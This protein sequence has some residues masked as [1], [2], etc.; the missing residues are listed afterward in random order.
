M[1]LP[2]R[3]FATATKGRSTP[4]AISLHRKPARRAVAL[5]Y[6]LFCAMSMLF[7]GFG[8][9]AQAQSRANLQIDPSSV[10]F[11]GIA[12]AGQEVSQRF[13]FTMSNFGASEFSE[14]A[15]DI[16]F[17]GVSS[18][19]IFT[20][21]ALDCSG[22]VAV[23]QIGDCIVDI[24][25]EAENVEPGGPVTITDIFNVTYTS[26]GEGSFS[27]PVTINACLL[28]TSDAADE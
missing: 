26:E 5:F 23:G 24:E 15:T 6:A 10:T 4:T 13:R 2:I 27:A 18:R 9:N 11:D 8:S 20:V 25:F 19:G 17:D 7:L 1:S 3:T 12:S 14:T 16:D 21:S 22:E 28:Y